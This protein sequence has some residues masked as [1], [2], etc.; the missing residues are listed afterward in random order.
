MFLRL[1]STCFAQCDRK[2]E[3][4]PRL[5]NLTLKEWEVQY[6]S[7]GNERTWGAGTLDSLLKEYYGI[8]T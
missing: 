3:A 8:A 2:E 6:S 5:E 7:H 4:I 1:K